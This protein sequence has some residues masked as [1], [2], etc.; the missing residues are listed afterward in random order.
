MVPVWL[1]AVSLGFCTRVI[2][3]AS[4]TCLCLAVWLWVVCPPSL[5]WIVISLCFCSGWEMGTY[6]R[7][8]SGICM[9]DT[10]AWAHDGGQRRCQQEAGLAKGGRQWWCSGQPWLCASSSLTCACGSHSPSNNLFFCW[11]HPEL[12]LGA[13]PKDTFGESVFSAVKWLF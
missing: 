3:F 4:W 1:S 5:C 7:W 8:W 10:R 13:V 9:L 11:N 6:L 12:L 2:G